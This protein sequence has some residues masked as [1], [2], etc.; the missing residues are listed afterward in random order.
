MGSGRETTKRWTTLRDLNL[1][2]ITIHFCL[3]SKVRN[4]RDNAAT[5]SL[6]VMLNGDADLCPHSSRGCEPV[7]FLGRREGN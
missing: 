5:V 7:G 4:G 2:Q 6:D 1:G 3:L